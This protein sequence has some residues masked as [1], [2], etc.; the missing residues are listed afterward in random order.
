MTK[1]STRL[2]LFLAAPMLAVFGQARADYLNWTYSTTTNPPV[3]TSGATLPTGG[4]DV[5]LTGYSSHAGGLSVP[6][7]G[8]DTIASVPINFD[9]HY[10]MTM[11]ITD[12]ATHDSGTLTFAGS[13]QGAL[14]PTTSTLVNSFN[15]PQSLS[16]DGHVYTVSI[17]QVNL[18]APPSPQQD[19]L[20][21]IRVSTATGGE[22]DG[23]G[24]VHGSPEPGTLVLGGLGLSSAGVR[25]CWNRM[26]R[27]VRRPA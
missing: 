11:T 5:Q 3:V 10:S 4:G 12:N 13:I 27:V 23:G 22:G 2:L 20:A 14:T 24:G 6:V 26:R 18:A 1:V 9:S 16:L 19:V 25:Y 17:P 8:Y 15:A 7:V 21:S